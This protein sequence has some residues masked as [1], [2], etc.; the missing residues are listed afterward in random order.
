VQGAASQS[1]NLT[2]WQNSSGVVGSSVSKDSHL[3][4]GDTQSVGSNVRLAIN[5]GTSP[6]TGATAQ[7]FVVYGVDSGASQTHFG[8]TTGTTPSIGGNADYWNSYK[9]S[10]GWIF[11]SA[12]SGTGTTRRMRWLMNDSTV[13]LVMN[14]DGRTGIGNVLSPSAQLHVLSSASGLQGLIVQGAA[15]QTANLQEWQNSSTT[16]LSFI[17]SS[18]KINLPN[19]GLRIADTNASHYLVV[20]PGSNITADRTLTVTT[21]D[22]DR[23]LTINSNATVSS[24]TAI[25]TITFIID[26][27]GAT[28]ATGV[29]GDLEI[30]FGC[31]INQVSMMA[32]QSGSIVVDIWKDSWANY[33]PTVADT[34][35][36]SAKPTISSATKSQDA[37]LTGWTTSITAGDTLRFNVDSATTIQ[38]LTISLK[39]TKT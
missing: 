15:S 12:K 34:I 27:G 35:T 8:V 13:V 32:D 39:V 3:I 11:N 36:A 29:K 16:V 28:I 23:T 30:P 10:N 14:S 7:A 26:G 5:G 6:A 1:A 25:A 22:A 19:T 37:T 24:N 20:A 33:P 38:R 21:G 4:L 31:T 17:D 2:E 9:D 18:G